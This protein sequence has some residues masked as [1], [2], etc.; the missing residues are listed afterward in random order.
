MNKTN[1]SIIQ[2]K[3]FKDLLINDD[4]VKKNKNKNNNNNIENQFF[5]TVSSINNE[6]FSEQNKDI[7]KHRT[8]INSIKRSENRNNMTNQ[9]LINKLRV[10][11]RNSINKKMN[12]S[13]KKGERTGNGSLSKNK[14]LSKYTPK[15]MN[16]NNKTFFSHSNNNKDYK[17]KNKLK[18]IKVIDLQ[19]NSINIDFES[20]NNTT[21]D[22]FS[23]YNTINKNNNNSNILKNKITRLNTEANSIN[24]SKLIIHRNIDVKK[25]NKFRLIKEFIT[26]KVRNKNNLLN[27]KNDNVN[28]LSN[29]NRNKIQINKINNLIKKVNINSINNNDEIN[30]KRKC[31]IQKIK[32]INEKE[33]KNSLLYGDNNMYNCMSSNNIVTNINNNDNKI[34]INHEKKITPFIENSYIKNNQNKKQI[35]NL[36]NNTINNIN[37]FNNCNYIYLLNNGDKYIKINRQFKE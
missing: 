32:N 5:N 19:N 3:K 11:C 4:I 33:I 29:E 18:H 9:R 34:K 10:K 14:I 28:D 37:N 23:Q 30:V 20:K 22:Y 2:K 27:I 1:Y 7:K 13:I 36:N 8:S 17:I 15:H 21:T 24:K 31:K 25:N 16:E 35:Q 12:N 26:E 6:Y